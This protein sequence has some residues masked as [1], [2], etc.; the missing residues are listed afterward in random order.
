MSETNRPATAGDALR[1]KVAEV[2]A[3]SRRGRGQPEVAALPSPPCETCRQIK[4]SRYR[5]VEAGDRQE[6]ARMA[7]AMGIHQ[8]EAH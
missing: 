7:V 6:A 3:R 4:G 8:R 1:A 2:N 5:A